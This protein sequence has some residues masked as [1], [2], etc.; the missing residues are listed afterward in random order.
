MG[1]EY[2]VKPITP[3]DA[4]E[5]KRQ[6]A[7]QAETR[8]RL[9]TLLDADDAS[10]EAALNEYVDTKFK[11][12]IN[13]VHD[14]IIRY[15]KQGGA[16]VWARSVGMTIAEE[17]RQGMAEQHKIL[18]AEMK[19]LKRQYASDRRAIRKHTSKGGQR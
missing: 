12:I 8:F 6:A 9:Q 11:H 15:L 17:V 4:D 16:E 14:D 7:K 10:L 5:R 18:M 3:A 1:N 19:A 2:T 13:Y